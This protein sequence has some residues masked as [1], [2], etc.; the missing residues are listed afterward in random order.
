MAD[1]K[2]SALTS[3]SGAVAA[4]DLLPIIDDP[5]GTP[6]SC[7]VTADVLKDFF[8]NAPVFAAG[9]ASASSWPKF[10]SGTVLTTAEAGAVELDADC[11]YGCT[12]AGNRGVIPVVHIIRADSTRTFTSNTSSQAIFTSP[13]NGRITLETGTYLVN[14]LLHFTGMSA[15]SGNL[16]VNLLGAGTATVAAW[17]WH[18]TGAD[19]V[20]GAAG[21]QGGSL[22]TT[23]TS[24]AS[25]ATAATNST[26]YVNVKGSFEVTGAGTMIPSIT[27]VTASAS[28]LSIGSYLTMQ[29][30]GS[31]SV[32]SVGQWD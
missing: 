20:A 19:A 10:T 5:A 32:V 15:T 29:R 2:I 21:N 30:I 11:F 31:T 4:T 17:L 13:A 3:L 22:M 16:Q 27:M 14:G 12:D 26:L 6:L 9:S 25:I 1:T 23:S 7:K 8:E 28:V 24:P 18:A